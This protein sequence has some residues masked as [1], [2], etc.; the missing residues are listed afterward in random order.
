MISYIQKS[1]MDVIGMN[2]KII[3]INDKNYHSD[4]ECKICVSSDDDDDKEEEEWL[5]D[6]ANERH[7]PSLSPRGPTAD[8]Y[9]FSV[10][11]NESVAKNF[12]QS[13]STISNLSK[14]Q[15][16]IYSIKTRTVDNKVK[17]ELIQDQETRN[18]ENKDSS[19]AADKIGFSGIKKILSLCNWKN[20]IVI[21]IQN[22][23]TFPSDNLNDLI[24]L[25]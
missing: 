18:L 6:D 21:V 17:D 16:A 11:D 14:K 15:E 20:P 25:V 8:E 2:E 19:T 22:I 3:S 23:K 5:S 24:Y 1:I 4:E 7:K 13:N 9:Q 10:F 12:R